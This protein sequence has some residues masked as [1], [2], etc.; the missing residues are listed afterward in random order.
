MG[1]LPRLEPGITLPAAAFD[2]EPEREKLEQVTERE[3]AEKK[4]SA[5]HDEER[6]P[7]GALHLRHRL[8]RIGLGC[9]SIILRAGLHDRNGALIP[10]L[11]VDGTDLRCG[12][13]TEEPTIAHYWED[14]VVV[15]VDIV[16]DERPVRAS[17]RLV[18]IF[19][20]GCLV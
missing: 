4:L 10:L 9:H 16:L 13:A 17:C 8:Q 19:P 11:P 3:N 6:A 1:G 18:G 12:D 14:L 15:A 5:T 20:K 2:F 7:R